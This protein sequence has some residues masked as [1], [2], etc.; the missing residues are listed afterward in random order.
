M[1]IPLVELLPER[2]AL[3]RTSQLPSAAFLEPVLADEVA[4]RD[5]SAATHR[6]ALARRPDRQRRR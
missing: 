6:A 2:L 5:R 3:A 4:W 1:S